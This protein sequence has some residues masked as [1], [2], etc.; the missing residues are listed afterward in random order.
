MTRFGSPSIG[1]ERSIFDISSINA[2]IELKLNDSTPYPLPH[3]R[4]V[5]WT[6][7][8]RLVPPSTL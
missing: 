6:A 3:L 7:W 1:V 5:G 4:P 2:P 8:F